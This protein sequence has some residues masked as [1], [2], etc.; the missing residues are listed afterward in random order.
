MPKKLTG[1]AK[2][3]EASNLSVRIYCGVADNN[4]L[5]PKPDLPGVFPFLAIDI[6]WDPGIPNL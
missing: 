6:S 5:K 2:P 3:G 1:D 4:F